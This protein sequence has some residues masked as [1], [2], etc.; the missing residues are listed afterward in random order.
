M[1]VAF[2]F[3]SPDTSVELEELRPF[4]LGY[5]ERERK[6]EELGKTVQISTSWFGMG[7]RFGGFK[8]CIICTRY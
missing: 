5:R 8:F 7:Q 3:S 6:K 4:K 1:T 2:D